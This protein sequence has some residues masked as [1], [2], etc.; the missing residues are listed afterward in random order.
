MLHEL[1][2]VATRWKS[3]GTVL[4]LKAG[5][6]EDIQAGNSSDPRARACLSWVVMAWLRRDYNVRRFGEPTWQSLAESVGH[7]EGGA[8]TAVAR[9]IA[10][11]HKEGGM[12][13][14]CPFINLTKY[15]WMS[16]WEPH[17]S[18]RVDDHCLSKTINLAHA[19]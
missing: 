17:I 14:D 2:P 5:L 1:T 11:R 4:G 18:C 10:A 19:I 6:L 16:M 9:S 12:L 15:D 13:S 3:I 7:P 8:N